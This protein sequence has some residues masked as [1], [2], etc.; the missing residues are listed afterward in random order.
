[1]ESL[2]RQRKTLNEIGALDKIIDLCLD[3]DLCF[4]DIALRIFDIRASTDNDREFDA[5][6]NILDNL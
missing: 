3:Y 5:L 1:M 4:K 2:V 6:T